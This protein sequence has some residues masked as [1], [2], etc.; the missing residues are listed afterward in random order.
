MPPMPKSEKIWYNGEL[1]DWDDAKPPAPP[2]RF[3][4][5][6][7]SKN[8]E[9]P[10]ADV[11]RPL[12]YARQSVADSS[13]PLLPLPPPP[14]L[15]PQPDFDLDSPGPPSPSRLLACLALDSVQ[16]QAG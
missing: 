14:D 9:P 7:L 8:S 16:S 1:V 6:K 10:R 13:A 12:A 5:S 11:Q 15:S 2:R 3:L 4:M